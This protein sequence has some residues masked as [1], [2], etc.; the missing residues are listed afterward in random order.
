[1]YRKVCANVTAM[2]LLTLFVYS[3]GPRAETTSPTPTGTDSASDSLINAPA[4]DIGLLG[5]WYGGP[6]YTS[7]V[8]GDYLYYGTGGAIR[9][10]KIMHAI[11]QDKTAW[12]EV[13]TIQSS[14]VVRGLK[15]IDKSDPLHPIE[16]GN[17]EMT[18]QAHG[19]YASDHRAYV[20]SLD[21]QTLQN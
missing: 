6:I 7:V 11:M 5:R 16:I 12:I 1:M 20:V 13:A 15:L 17:Y 21:T 14:G 3:S 8:S 19:V 9:V 2:L 18:G 10:M 4:P